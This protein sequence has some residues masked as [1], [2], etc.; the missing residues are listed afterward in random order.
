MLHVRSTVI[1]W[2][3]TVAKIVIDCEDPYAIDGDVRDVKWFEVFVQGHIQILYYDILSQML[4]VWYIYQ[5]LSEQNH[6][7]VGKYTMH[8]AL[9]HHTLPIHEPFNHQ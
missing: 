7:N 1:N 8:W 2:L 5:H 4:H 3:D 9:N 6:P